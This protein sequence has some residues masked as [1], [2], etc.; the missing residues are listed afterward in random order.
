MKLT[1]LNLTQL[2]RLAIKLWAKITKGQGYQPFGYDWPTLW[3]TQP[4]R[5]RAY[6]EVLMAVKSVR[7]I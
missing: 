2:N 4:E 7:G 1:D 5:A 3:A 6:T